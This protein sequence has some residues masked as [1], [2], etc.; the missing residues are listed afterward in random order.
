MREVINNEAGALLSL[1]NFKPS[2]EH[3]IP[4]FIRSKYNLARRYGFA[5][6]RPQPTELDEHVLHYVH[7]KLFRKNRT[8]K[9]API[10][11][12]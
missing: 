3:T 10:P 12:L 7:P 6:K 2:L 8:D 9:T 5:E 11:T 4:S 1:E